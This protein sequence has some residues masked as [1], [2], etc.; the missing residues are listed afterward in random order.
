MARTRQ[1][2]SLWV[3]FGVG[4]LACD[5]GASGD[6]RDGGPASRSDA[7]A[8]MNM[9]SDAGT[10][11]ASEAGMP[12]AAALGD[13]ATGA[14]GDAL[15]TTLAESG[16]YAVGNTTTLGPGVLPFTPRFA[17]WSDGAD[18]QRWLWLPKGAQIDT[19]DMDFWL[20]PVGTKS[21]K[22]FSVDGKKIETRL[23]QKTAEGW[24]SIAFA[25]NDAETDAVA[26]PNGVENARGTDHDIP[27]RDACAACHEGMPD[28]LLGVSAIQLSHSKPGVT[29]ASL[30]TSG[31]LSDPPSGDFGLPD[32]TEWN[33]L[34]YLHANCGSCH[35]PMA[36]AFDRVDLDLWLRAATLDS[37][38][39]T[40]SYKSLVD[41]ALTDT[42]SSLTKRIA[43]GDPDQSGVILRMMLRGDE[44]AMPP[45]ASEIPDDDGLMLMR[46]WISGL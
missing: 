36:V 20:F 37:A 5:A 44:K 16:L 41:V 42:E 15:P 22:E 40:G 46:T 21:W 24:F 34:G 43:V 28:R 33:A 8:A 17:L 19:T 6:T 18:K 4:L 11:A 10:D 45:L 35:N 3:L 31:A 2:L 25:W 13:A 39:D 29:I 23:L 38:S 26:V 12:D 9:D 30:Q 1:R 27:K 32:T 7:S 14:P